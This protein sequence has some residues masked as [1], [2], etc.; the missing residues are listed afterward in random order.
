MAVPAHNQQYY[1]VAQY[2]ELEQ[3]TG[4]KYQYDKGN[5]AL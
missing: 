3:Q 2:L 1:T 5:D 4:V